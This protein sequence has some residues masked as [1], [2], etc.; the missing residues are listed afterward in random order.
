M[1]KND[2]GWFFDRKDEGLWG[3][4]SAFYYPTC[5]GHH[6]LGSGHSENRYSPSKGNATNTREIGGFTG[7]K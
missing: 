6:C 1:T 7:R 4:N 5:S 2:Y 3:N